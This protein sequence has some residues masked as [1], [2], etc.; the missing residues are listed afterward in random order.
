MRK[1]TGN[2]KEEF[3]TLEE[4]FF[5]YYRYFLKT[6]FIRRVIPLPC[7]ILS[8]NFFNGPIDEK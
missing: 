6:F 8:G 4:S 5:C 7:K 2:P 3:E 1:N